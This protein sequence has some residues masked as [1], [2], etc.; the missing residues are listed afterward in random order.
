M[1]KTIEKLKSKVKVFQVGGVSSEEIANAEQKL[2]LKFSDEYKEYLSNY[3]IISFGSHEF[4]G[5][6]VNGYL[7]VVTATEKERNLGGNFPK[8]CILI[9][10]NGIDGVLTI[11]DENGIVYSFDGKNKTKIASSFS[12]FLNTLA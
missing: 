4:S 8:D 12:E 3:G 9:E 7:N 1:K 10:N 5:L 2:N 11:M 6:G